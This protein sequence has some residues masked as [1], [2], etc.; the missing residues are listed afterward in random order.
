[1]IKL[2][3][4]SKYYYSKG[5]ISSGIS[6]VNLDFN[7]GEFVIITGESGS[8]KTTLL[9]VVSG[10]DSYEEGEMYINGVETSHYIESDFEEYRKK[11]IGN[12]FQD[13]NL[14]NSYTVYQ[15]IEL[16]LMIKG[17]G[18]EEIKKRVPEILER[19]GLTSHAKSKVSKLSGG[20]KQR[21]A[22]AR[23]LAKDTDIIVADEPT[24]NLDS[25]SAEGIVKLLSQ[26]ARDKLV[27]V[28]THNYEQFE[29]YATRKIK[30]HDGKVAEDKAMG[31]Q[32]AAVESDIT[33]QP[34]AKTNK[35]KQGKKSAASKKGIT[36]G[37]RIRLGVRNT[38]NI[39][40]KFI[41]MLI[42]FMFVV[43]GISSL[44]TTLQHQQAE[45]DKLGYN[46]YFYNYS[47]DR[48]VLKKVDESSFKEDDYV[49]MKNVENVKSVVL[50]D[51]MLDTSMYIEDGDFSFEVFPR[52]IGDFNGKLAAGRMP[53]SRNEAILTS[54]KEE[55]YF[56]DE[57]INSIINRKYTIMVGEDKEI[58]VTI[59]GCAYKPE[60][61]GYDAM[62]YTG[63]L[64]VMDELLGTMREETYNYNSDITVNMND[65]EQQYMPGDSYY[66]IVPNSKV[67]K[68]EALV[69]E[70]MDNFYGESGA[71][72]KVLKITAETI[73]YKDS[74]ELQIVDTYNE[75][76]FKT[77]TGISDY[78]LHNG[79]VYVNQKDYD[80][81]FLKGNYQAT[82][83][84]KDVRAMDDTLAALK[85]M[86]YVT[87]PL[88]ETLVN[89]SE[90]ISN[91]ILVPMAVVI[92]LAIFFIAYFVIRLILKS[93]S[94]YFTILRMLG[95][96][97]KHIRRILDTEMTLVVNIAYAVFI[98]CIL[99]IKYGIIRV[100]YMA[101]LV[102]YLSIPDYVILYV[103]IFVMAYLI[104]GK[105]AR[106]LFKKTAMNV[107]R[108]GDR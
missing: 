91:I 77:K 6:R 45:E 58:P 104:S 39:L 72:G 79:A 75:E 69:F 88:K 84:V 34:D 86:G 82:V 96:A 108:E 46:D 51:I 32:R 9:N 99:L 29:Q 47:E 31:I 7:I 78:E 83:Y 11:Y 4:V 18:R 107:F 48:I 37:G 80:E 56:D 3:N 92:A 12:I 35:T 97:K 94:T 62:M 25:V 54:Y 93:R 21:V 90:G 87:L 14:V 106:Y 71:K 33:E 40:P 15:N 38:F 61:A 57:T 44:Y 26:I 41:L 100:A 60:T 65:K 5:M 24:G 98:G 68:G 23:A 36:G 20:Q 17:C 105:F 27:I 2:K 53:K 63:S 64:Y 28:V 42:V 30:M 85:T 16:I 1:M 89:F 49:A 55:F 59:V 8:G 22:I 74:I 67:K 73:Y 81:L 52:V 95:M 101:E 70:E 102:Q 10:L 13:F 76:T 103:L 66:R 19:V 50:N 43:F